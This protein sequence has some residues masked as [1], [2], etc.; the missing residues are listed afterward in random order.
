MKPN[1]LNPFLRAFLYNSL[2]QSKTTYSIELMNINEKTVNVLNVMQ[3]SLIR[4]MLRLHKS[5]HMSNI[6]KSLKILYIKHLICKYKINL[7]RQL[8]NHSVCSN[9]WDK[10]E[11][12]AQGQAQGLGVRV[13][14][15]SSYS[16]FILWFYRLNIVFFDSR[17]FI[18]RMMSVRP[19]VGNT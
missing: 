8:L 17:A 11:G 1:G 5:C 16:F 12:Q 13:R 14:V 3:N 6:M 9:R 10:G 18:A 2:C 4:Y 7:V 15:G 19:S